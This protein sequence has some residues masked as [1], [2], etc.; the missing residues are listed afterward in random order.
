VPIAKIFQPSSVIHEQYITLSYCWGKQHFLTSVSANIAAHME[1]LPESNLPQTFTD[2]I[3]TTRQLGFRYLWI[4]VLCIIQDSAEDKATEIG[5]MGSIYSN[6]ILTIAVVNAVGV[7][8]GFLKTK[9]RLQVDIPCR[10]SDG[11]IGT[12]QVSPQKTI[13]LWQE[14]LYT[15]A[16][17]LQEN[18]PSSRLLLFTNRSYMAMRIMSYETPRYHPRSLPG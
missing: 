8:D 15:R 12:V 6:S 16:W 14:P 11:V 2:A 7:A 5:A 18:L 9:P 17:C 1:G 13:D 4:D 10:C 3:E